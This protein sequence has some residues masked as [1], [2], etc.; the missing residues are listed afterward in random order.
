MIVFDHAVGGGSG[1]GY[2]IYVGSPHE[3]VYHKFLKRTTF[4]GDAYYRKLM[5]TWSQIPTEFVP[6]LVDRSWQEVV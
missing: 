6:D 4:H 5:G 3:L 1:I 2:T